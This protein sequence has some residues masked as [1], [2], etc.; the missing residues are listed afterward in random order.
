MADVTK[1][2]WVPLQ[3][4]EGKEGDVEDFLKSGEALV[5]DEPDTTAWFALQMGGGAYG[6]FDVF[7]D[8]AGRDAHL[9]GKVA[10]ALMEQ[11]EELFSP[12]PEINKLDVIASKL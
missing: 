5:G 10:A 12:A 11:A 1:A 6:I 2:L 9:N 7:L 3:A 8:D 4:K